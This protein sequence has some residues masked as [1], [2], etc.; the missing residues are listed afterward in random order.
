MVWLIR[1]ICDGASV[2]KRKVPMEVQEAVQACIYGVGK[3]KAEMELRL[4][5]GSKSIKG[6]QYISNKWVKKG[7]IV[8]FSHNGKVI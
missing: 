1:K 2:Q 4:A 8:P 5:K 7:N 6:Y 3:A